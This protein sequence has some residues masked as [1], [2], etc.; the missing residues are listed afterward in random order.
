MLVPQLLAEEPPMEINSLLMRATFK[1]AGPE[2]LGTVFIVGRPVP[3]D[4]KMVFFV[5][6]TAAHVLRD[7]KGDEAVLFLRIR[8]GEDFLK[9]HHTV[10]VRHEG[11]ARWTEHP[12]ADVAVMYV[13]V[14]SEVDIQAI[15]LSFLATD[16]ALKKYEIHPGDA[17]SC[18]GF[19]YGA[20]ANEAGFPV[21]RSGEIA[22]YP[23]TP[24]AKIKTFLFD[25]RVFGGNSG[26]PVYFVG[27]NR[28]YGGGTMLGETIQFLAGL[29]S[30][31]KIL[32]EEI[33]SL[34][35]TRKAKHPLSLAVV[36]HAAMIREAIE[37]LPPEPNL[38]SN[39]K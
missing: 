28:T 1:I 22:S 12:D 6:V 25:F 4:E 29:V 38:P 31:E 34:T 21:L 16:Q 23:L 10:K 33:K 19:P 15:P 9:L 2:S 14:P 26:G 39:S 24:T 11:K 5:L 32:E 35:E 13:S 27:S 30:Q 18:L 7:I 20:E 37:I 3:G 17:L 36:V 8:R